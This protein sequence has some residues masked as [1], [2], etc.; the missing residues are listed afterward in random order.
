MASSLGARPNP[1]RAGALVNA[2]KP[3]VLIVG[4]LRGEL[5]SYL[6]NLGIHV[7]AAANE[8]DLTA[9]NKHEWDICLVEDVSRQTVID[10]LR[11]SRP[12]L[13]IVCVSS[14]EKARTSASA[15]GARDQFGGSHKGLSAADVLVYGQR[16]EETPPSLQ[17]QGET[18]YAIEKAHILSM[19]KR[20]GGNKSRTAM[21]LGIDRV[22]L[23]KKL[24]AYK[25]A[26]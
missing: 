12:E 25:Q 14:M 16:G 22:T 26:D 8:G 7:D 11:R 24:R 9:L 13:P 5:A 19:L 15:P 10:G 20:Y 3:R 18:I 2:C 17:P 23:Y 21:A 4:E 1:L 6:C